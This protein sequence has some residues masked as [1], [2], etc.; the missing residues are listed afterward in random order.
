MLAKIADPKITASMLDPRGKIT[1]ARLNKRLSRL[2]PD[3]DKWAEWRKSPEGKAVF[4][5]A[6]KSLQAPKKPKPK[7]QSEELQ[8]SQRQDGK[9]E[10]TKVPKKPSVD[11]SNLTASKKQRRSLPAGELPLYAA[12]SACSNHIANSLRNSDIYTDS[13]FYIEADYGGAS[14]IITRS[15]SEAAAKELLFIFKLSMMEQHGSFEVWKKIG[16]QHEL[17]TVGG[18]SLESIGTGLV[19]NWAEIDKLLGSL[20]SEAAQS[21]KKP[22]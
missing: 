11:L 17:V 16:D 4:Q 20:K 5:R 21:M 22:A 9:Q 7:P 19:K 12:A 1:D 8:P 14:P 3:W 15:G 10:A 18:F 6:I 13:F 2:Y